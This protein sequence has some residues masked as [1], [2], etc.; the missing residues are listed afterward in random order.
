MNNTFIEIITNI[1]SNDAIAAIVLIVLLIVWWLSWKFVIKPLIDNVDNVGNR[2]ENY[3][4]NNNINRMQQDIEK[5]KENQLSEKNISKDME[6]IVDFIKTNTDLINMIKDIN[7]N[8]SDIILTRD[9]LNQI[10]NDLSQLR[11]YIKVNFD[12]HKI[13]SN[14]SEQIKDILRYVNDNKNI[15]GKY[16]EQMIKLILG[17]LSSQTISRFDRD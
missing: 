5:I 17:G 6:Y 15:D 12:N 2:I 4:K 1:M 13:L 14:V 11:D 8:S 9:N 16:L 7:K 10:N 3:F